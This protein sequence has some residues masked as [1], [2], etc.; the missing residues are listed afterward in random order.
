M[1]YHALPSSMRGYRGWW[2]AQSALHSKTCL[3]SCEA[4]G[5][6]AVETKQSL[7]WLPHLSLR[8]REQILLAKGHKRPAL[9]GSGVLTN[10]PMLIF[11]LGK[12]KRHPTP[13]GISNNADSADIRVT[14]PNGA[15]GS[16]SLKFGVYVWRGETSSDV[17]CRVLMHI[18]MGCTCRA[19]CTRFP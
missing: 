4:S 18:C 6:E 13:T 11:P 19:H 17:L 12:H 1:E 3:V 5:T 14:C 9:I 16:P 15:K 10:Q 8:S 2:F 7:C